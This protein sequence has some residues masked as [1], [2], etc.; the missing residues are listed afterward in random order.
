M[1]FSE[2]FI[3]AYESAARSRVEAADWKHRAE[4]AEARVKELEAQNARLREALEAITRRVP[5]MTSRGDYRDGQL[6][7][8]EAC[9]DVAKAALAGT[10]EA[11]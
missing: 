8:L 5:I 6:H 3:A 11:K 1:S 2:D 7:A 9:A 10:E 4:A